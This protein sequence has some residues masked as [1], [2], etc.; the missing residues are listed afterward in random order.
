M[1]VTYTF[2]PSGR[3]KWSNISS[4]YLPKR[5]ELLLRSVFA[6]PNASNRGL[7]SRKRREEEC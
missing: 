2:P 7:D 5:D 4:K 3:P 1:E 6:F